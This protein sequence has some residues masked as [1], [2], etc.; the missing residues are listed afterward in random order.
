[1]LEDKLIE[2]PINTGKV[3][4]LKNVTSIELR[5]G[6]HCGI[7]L[8]E[9]KDHLIFFELAFCGKNYYIAYVYKDGEKVFKTESDKIREVKREIKDFLGKL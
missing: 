6:N 4:S 1:M 9:E 2:N 7:V 8:L 3:D 5:T